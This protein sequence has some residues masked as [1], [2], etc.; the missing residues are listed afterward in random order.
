MNLNIPGHVPFSTENA[1]FP[2]YHPK[3]G[4]GIHVTA[5]VAHIPCNAINI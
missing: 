2:S 1:R 3:T 5:L 4:G